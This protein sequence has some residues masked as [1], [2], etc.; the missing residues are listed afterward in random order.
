MDFSTYTQYNDNI[1][2]S[3]SQ[4]ISQYPGTTDY[5]D[6][7]EF[8]SLNQGSGLT[9][10]R[11]HTKAQVFSMSKTL[12]T[13]EP[14]DSVNMIEGFT[15]CNSVKVAGKDKSFT[16]TCDIQQVNQNLTKNKCKLN[17]LYKKFNCIVPKYKSASA[18]LK[19]MLLQ[20]HG[21]MQKNHSLSGGNYKLSSGELVYIT[22]KGVVKSYGSESI[23]KATSGKNGC[24]SSSAKSID[25]SLDKL[26]E[27]VEPL[28]RGTN[29]K[30]T[31]SLISY[32]RIE[33]CKTNGTS[34]SLMI[35]EIQVYDDTN[36]NIASSAKLTASSQKDDKAVSNIT[37]N[38]L[39]T[40]GT[41]YAET[42]ANDDEYFMLEF[43]A[44]VNI[45]RIVLYVPEDGISNANG[46]S[47][48][49]LDSNKKQIYETINVS[50]NTQQEF[51]I[52]LELYGQSCG[53]EG[54]NVYVNQFPKTDNIG[55]VYIGCYNDSDQQMMSWDGSEPMS[56]KDCLQKAVESNSQYYGLQDTD[57]NGLSRCVLSNDITKTT[58]LGPGINA[59]SVW[60]TNTSSSS[61]MLMLTNTGNLVVMDGNNMILWQSYTGSTNQN[62]ITYTEKQGY[63]YSSTTLQTF[64]S[65]TS[66]SEVQNTCNQTATCVGYS[67]NTDDGGYSL[68]S[69]LQGGAT[70]SNTNFFTKVIPW[71]EQAGTDYSGNSLSVYDNVPLSTCKTNC[72]QT[73][74]CLGFTFT[75]EPD[76]NGSCDIKGQF[77]GNGTPSSNVN[78]YK[79]T[80]LVNAYLMMN[81]DGSLVL[82]QGTPNDG[83]QTQLWSSNTNGATAN[84][85][86]NPSWKVTNCKDCPFKRNYI[87]PGESL[88]IGNMLPSNSGKAVAILNTDGNFVVQTA[89][90]KC[91]KTGDIMSGASM[92]NSVYMLANA[93][94]TIQTGAPTDGVE[95]TGS[96]T[97]YQNDSLGSCL[98]SCENTSECK[99]ISFDKDNNTCKLYSSATAFDNSKTTNS[100]LINVNNPLDPTNSHHNKIGYVDKNSVLHEYTN[101]MVTYS[102]QYDTY[103]NTTSKYNDIETGNVSSVN[104]NGKTAVEYLQDKCNA[105][106]KCAGFTYTSTNGSYALK[107]K[108]I[109]PLPGKTSSMDGTNFYVRKPKIKNNGNDC[110]T[111]IKEIT[112]E[113][114]AHYDKGDNMD[115]SFQCG[116]PTE[117]KNHQ[118]SIGKMRESMD[119]IIRKVTALTNTISQQEAAMNVKEQEIVHKIQK[120]LCKLNTIRAQLGK[121]SNGDDST[122]T[123]TTASGNDDMF[124]A[125]GKILSSIF[126]PNPSSGSKNGSSSNHPLEVVGDDDVLNTEGYTTLE[127][128]MTEVTMQN[129]QDDRGFLLYGTLAIVGALLVFQMSKPLPR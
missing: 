1:N 34:K 101:D 82:Y 125:S 58:S 128:T 94:Y 28:E 117:I 40:T 38:N 6:S 119:C 50:G 52:S 118:A 76:G 49:L 92:T 65:Q 104:L 110:S 54:K 79:R 41:S 75:G 42:L 106:C 83:A 84:T 53:N 88:R 111:T 21:Q 80:D 70:S 126:N 61:A 95:V 109:Y 127:T 77:V 22:E 99:V 8:P 108:N 59:S 93:K 98:A 121:D 74:K 113:Q 73:D 66:V 78:T 103:E 55:S 5:M 15:S 2:T 100:Y 85:I 33:N 90:V 14:T 48:F 36:T 102:S 112:S 13:V 29:M 81:D 43:S 47:I 11:N 3:I 46:S 19:E 57:S 123:T 9:S 87:L 35:T 10:Q 12:N 17:K 32:V 4:G 31:T 44:E 64:D 107:N 116:Y 24:P 51:S 23:F 16:G 18:N 129:T 7:H 124:T 97:T 122:T 62:N 89:N 60:S 96:Q 56:A 120:K 45:T 26:S 20:H 63:D 25:V 37:N 30:S 39:D 115:S 67:N 105:N 72:I 27:S 69:S 71:T 86:V 114:W 91:T 68:R